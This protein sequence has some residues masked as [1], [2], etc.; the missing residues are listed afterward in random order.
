MTITASVALEL[1][2][3]FGVSQSS[4][5]RS[6]ASRV[7]TLSKLGALETGLTKVL[8]DRDSDVGRDGIKGTGAEMDR[9]I[10]DSG[11]FESVSKEKRDR[12]LNVVQTS[13]DRLILHRILERKAELAV[14]REKLA[15]QR[16]D[17]AEADVEIKHWAKRNSDV[18]L[19]EVLQQ[20]ANQWADQAQK[21]LE[22]SNRLFREHQANECQ[23]IG[24]LRR[25]YFEEA[26]R[27][28]Q[29]RIDELSV[30]QESNPMTRIY[31]ST[32]RG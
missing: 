25:T 24:E 9:E 20:Q 15:K 3:R 21:E 23:E 4:S 26:D 16:L 18:A 17:E 19:D 10:V 27:A 13:R 22:M 6:A 32:R 8:A 14:S 30:H 11:L 31:T 28:T 2:R 1:P 12:D 29:A 5:Q 7:H